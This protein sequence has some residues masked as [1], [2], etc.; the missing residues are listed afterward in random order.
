MKSK[1][2]LLLILAAL[3]ATASTSHAV[4]YS[5]DDGKSENDLGSTTGGTVTFA[6]GF[7]ASAGGEVIQSIEIAWGIV[8]NGTSFTARLWS[9]ANGDGSPSDAVQ[10]ASLSS[11]VSLANTD[12]FVLYDI[13]DVQLLPGNKFFVGFTITHTVG[14]FPGAFDQTTPRSTVSWA[15]LAPNFTNSPINTNASFGDF[16]IRANGGAAAV[17][18]GGAT[19][20]LLGLSLCGLAAARKR[21]G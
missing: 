5:I 11:T 20:F 2:Y 7:T 17:P 21:I 8:A 6:N 4:V 16:M 15:Q 13:P 10:L 1:K 12:T 18:E 14:E 9:D 19:A 3:A